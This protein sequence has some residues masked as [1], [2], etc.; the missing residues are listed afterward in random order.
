MNS[1]VTS[2]DDFLRIGIFMLFH[3]ILLNHTG[4]MPHISTTSARLALSVRSGGSMQLAKEDPNGST[5]EY[6]EVR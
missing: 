1:L 3:T 2:R 5:R 4:V 6:E